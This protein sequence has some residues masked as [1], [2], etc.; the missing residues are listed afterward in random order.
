MQQNCDIFGNKPWSVEVE[1]RYCEQNQDKTYLQSPLYMPL[2]FIYYKKPDR[3]TFD[4]TILLHILLCMPVDKECSWV[5]KMPYTR[6]VF[7]LQL[8]QIAF[9]VIY[10]HIVVECSVRM[11]GNLHLKQTNCYLILFYETD[12]LS[13]YFTL[14]V[15]QFPLFFFFPQFFFFIRY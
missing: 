3:Q 7:L 12:S 13:L 9:L 8:S 15:L 6:Y 2:K 11:Q 4:F 5:W 14:E 10:F 1:G